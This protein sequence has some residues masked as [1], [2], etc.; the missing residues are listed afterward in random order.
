MS[1]R[2]VYLNADERRQSLVLSR[3]LAAVQ[4]AFNAGERNTAELISV[5]TKTIAAEPAARL[6]YFSIVDPGTLEPINEITSSALIAVAVW[7][8]STRLIDNLILNPR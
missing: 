4:Q 2:N 8:G 7:L 3:S 5:G 1:S 6:D